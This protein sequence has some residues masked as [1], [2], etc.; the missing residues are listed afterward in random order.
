MHNNSSDE[1]LQNF[2]QETFLEKHAQSKFSSWNHLSCFCVKN[3]MIKV[4]SVNLFKQNIPILTYIFITYLLLGICILSPKIS[5]VSYWH[6]KN[7]PDCNQISI[8]NSK[9][10]WTMKSFSVRGLCPRS[11]WDVPST[12]AQQENSYVSRLDLYNYRPALLS[13]V[14]TQYFYTN[15]RFRILF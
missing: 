11:N 12:C 10:N 8:V 13:S 2:G 4:F 6:S 3:E 9:F 1:S 5:K 7:R 15:E 14:V